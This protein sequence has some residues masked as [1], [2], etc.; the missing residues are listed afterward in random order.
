MGDCEGVT[1]KEI[2]QISLI[3]FWW[4]ST[5]CTFESWSGCNMSPPISPGSY[6]SRENNCLSSF[7]WKNP[8]KRE[9]AAALAAPPEQALHVLL[10][11]PPPVL[12]CLRWRLPERLLHFYPRT[13]DLSQNGICWTK[14]LLLTNSPKYFTW[15]SS[16]WSIGWLAISELSKVLHIS[17]NP[18]LVSVRLCWMNTNSLFRK[19]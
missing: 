11:L 14:G 6:R 2:W 12:H 18:S 19:G 15:E 4:N 17:H 9:L 3:I 10:L 16:C 8:D 5:A 7:N 1:D 13:A